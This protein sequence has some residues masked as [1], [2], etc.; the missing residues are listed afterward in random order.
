M[1]R[2]LADENL[3]PRAVAALRALEH[4]VVWVRDDSPGISDEEVLAQAQADAR[5][6]I[7]SDKG[8]GDLVFVRQLPAEHGV[9]LL[10]ARR[11][12]A[13]RTQALVNAI[14]SREDWRHMFAT[15]DGERV[16]IASIPRR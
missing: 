10:R 1:A 5:A 2:F 4:D 16:R 11:S 15:V 9:I 14:E 6:V 3:W 8:F 7:T 12:Q 13:D